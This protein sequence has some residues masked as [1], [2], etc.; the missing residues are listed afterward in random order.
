MH[1]PSAHQRSD[2]AW[3][4][5]GRP[6]LEARVREPQGAPI[7]I[8][9]RPPRLRRSK[10]RRSRIGWGTEGKIVPVLICVL[11]GA[12]SYDEVDGSSRQDPPRTKSHPPPRRPRHDPFGA[13]A[14]R[15]WPALLPGPDLHRLHRPDRNAARSRS[16][17]RRFEF[18]ATVEAAGVSCG[19]LAEEG[20]G[21]IARALGGRSAQTRVRGAARPRG[22]ASRRLHGI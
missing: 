6:E 20:E 21:R 10:D 5:N 1:G 11:K 13:S 12:V 9:F 19:R 22:F 2:D 15:C 7:R 18:I 4:S 8:A 16:P 3:M 17:G 14:R